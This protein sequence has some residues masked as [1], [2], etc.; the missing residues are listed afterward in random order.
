MQIELVERARTGDHDAF[1]LLVRASGNRLYGIA[2][3]IL[4][5]PD[6]AQDAVQEAFALAWR[7]VRALRDPGAWDAWLY[8]LT[9]NA[10]YR[11]AKTKASATSSRSGSTP[12]IGGCRRSRA[13][14][15]P[16]CRPAPPRWVARR[17]AATGRRTPPTAA[18][19]SRSTCWTA[20]GEVV[21]FWEVEAAA[22]E[23]R[24][25]IRTGCFCNPGAS[26]TARG[27]TA[28]DMARVF[29][30]DTHPRT[31]SSARCCR[32]RRWA[33]SG[34]QSG[35]RRRSA[36][37]SGSSTTCGRSRPSA[38]ERRPPAPLP[39]RYRTVL[40]SGSSTSAIQASKSVRNGARLLLGRPPPAR[41]TSRSPPRRRRR[42]TRG[43]CAPPARLLPVG[44]LPTK[45][46]VSTRLCPPPRSTTT[47]FRWSTS[48]GK[49]TPRRR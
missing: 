2:K 7:D 25:S 36:T 32:A 27:I 26:E 39:R 41:R 42:R 37:S 31:R 44:T 40:P 10:C 30:L 47:S 23:Q 48:A 3:L 38:A 6:R 1:S 16:T 17:S 49:T 11:S 8:R 34:C 9:V 19:R 24:V 21:G 18:G 4:R 45:V 35:S 43:T 13:A 14:C 28:S 12:S 22:D 33:R 29:A 5:D 20:S 15:W 46:V